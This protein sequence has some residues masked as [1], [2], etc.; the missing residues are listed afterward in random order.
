L[1][2]K[3]CTWAAIAAATLLAGCGG[4]AAPKLLVGVDDDSVKWTAS[5]AQLLRVTAQLGLE[6]VRVTLPWRSGQRRPGRLERVYLRRIERL[7]RDRRVVVAV[8]GPADDA[9]RTREARDV[10]CG[11]VRAALHLAPDVRDVV[12]WNEANSRTYW[13]PR[14]GAASAYA[15][16]LARCYDVLHAARSDVDVLDST[17]AGHDAAGFL[18]AVGA[19]YRSSGRDRR[20]VDTFGHNPYPMLPTEAPSARHA[21]GWIG[22]GDYPVLVRTLRAAFGATGQPVPGDG[23]KIWYL[24]DGFQTSV[25]RGIRA[26]TGR[27]NVAAL[28]PAAEQGRRLADAVRLAYCQP[29]VGAFFNFELADET[30]L[31]GWQSGL[32]FANWRPKPAF[33]EFRRALADVAGGRVGC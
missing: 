27:E 7:A 2:G 8:Y 32:L 25:P 18:R 22:E 31:V 15:A 28:L 19:A 11:Y 21:S 12:I 33:D 23:A 9:P 1:L 29:E 24:E 13:R 16:L 6:A 14:R 4:K 26:Y 10:F 30:R 5:P 3:R 17:A 20:I